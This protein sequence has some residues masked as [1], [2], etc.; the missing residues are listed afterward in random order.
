MVLSWYQVLVIGADQEAV[1]VLSD[2][3][4]WV[5]VERRIRSYKRQGDIVGLARRQAIRIKVVQVLTANS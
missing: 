1:I 3:A 5:S 4:G 2:Q